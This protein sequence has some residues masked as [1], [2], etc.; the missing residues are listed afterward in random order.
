MNMAKLSFSFSFGLVLCAAPLLQAAP[1]IDATHNILSGLQDISNISIGAG[2]QYGAQLDKS[3]A[4][5][6]LYI[7]GL[8]L[9]PGLN[10]DSNI[11]LTANNS[12]TLTYDAN[13]SYTLGTAIS[14]DAFWTIDDAATLFSAVDSSVTPGIYDFSLE[15]LGGD[16]D[17]ST[18]ILAS[19]PLQLEVFP[20]LNV[21]ALGT[22]TPGTISTGQQ[23]TISAT[24]TNIMSSRDFVSTTWYIQTGAL[25][26]GPDNL[27]FNEFAGSWFNKIVA[28]GDSIT[29][30]HSVWHA[31][32]S[33]PL[34]T[35]GTTLGDSH[36]GII[37]GL[38]NGDGFFVVLSGP[39]VEV[40]PEPGTLAL[41]GLAAGTLLMKRRRMA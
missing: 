17:S 11:A 22:A 10:W 34:G 15:F 7:N 33:S 18:D 2:T 31:D 37:G 1:T 5:G 8:N 13:A 6:D 24:L 27:P 38:Y 26:M 16:G 40:V 28:P 36:L 19:L 12:G 4:D 9:V 30:L 41:L 39:T 21:S 23:T 20:F 35:Y 32:P 14:G 3:A 29:D 25:Q